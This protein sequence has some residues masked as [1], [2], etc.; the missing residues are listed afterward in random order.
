MSMSLTVAPYATTTLHVRTTGTTTPR[1]AEKPVTPRTAG[2]RTRRTLRPMQ[3]N[4]GIGDVVTVARSPIAHAHLHRAT[5]TLPYNAPGDPVVKP[6]REAAQWQVGHAQGAARAVLPVTAARTRKTHRK[7]AHEVASSPIPATPRHQQQHN[8]RAACA[9][10]GAEAG[11]VAALLHTMTPARFLSALDTPAP[12]MSDAYRQTLHAARLLARSGA[13]CDALM[14]CLPAKHWTTLQREALRI[15]LHASEAAQQPDAR[16]ATRRAAEQEVAAA[17]HALDYLQA[18]PAASAADLAHALREAKLLVPYFNRKHGFDSPRDV[19]LAQEMLL[20]Y[21][22][23]LR[24]AHKLRTSWHARW[25]PRRLIGRKKS[26]LSAM[27]KRMTGLRRDLAHRERERLDHALRQA[28]AALFADPRRETILRALFD[29]AAPEHKL[30]VVRQIVILRHLHAH[31][32]ADRRH[33]VA[34]QRPFFAPLDLTPQQMAQHTLQEIQR[35][36]PDLAGRDAALLQKLQ[37]EARVML[38][39]ASQLKQQHWR[40]PTV[41]HLLAWHAQW[42]AALDRAQLHETHD[43][44]LRQALTKLSKHLHDAAD[45]TADDPQMR[46]MTPDGVQR[47][48]DEM[49]GRMHNHSA[50]F[51]SG[52]NVGV[53]ARVV[54]S[55]LPGIGLRPKLKQI[56]GRDAVISVGQSLSG[57]YLAIGRQSRREGEIGVDAVFGS[58]AIFGTDA[59][60]LQ[61]NLS[62]GVDA[63]YKRLRGTGLMIRADKLLDADG[64]VITWNEA[65]HPA[66]GGM[67]SNRW[68]MQK[69]NAFLCRRC[70]L[71]DGAMTIPRDAAALWEDFAAAFFDS[72]NLQLSI[73]RDSKTAQT[74]GA[75]AQAAAKVGNSHLGMHASAG[76]RI[77]LGRERQ[78]TQERS[79]RNAAMNGGH[80][81][82]HAIVADAKL[83][84]ALPNVSTTGSAGG[85]TKVSAPPVHAVDAQARFA[86]QRHNVQYRLQQVDGKLAASCFRYE[87]VSTLADLKAILQRDADVWHGMTNGDAH[88]AHFYAEYA[89]SYGH[90]PNTVFYVI[91]DLR[92]SAAEQIDAIHFELTLLETRLAQAAYDAQAHWNAHIAALQ[93]RR[94]QIL[95]NRDNWLPYAIDVRLTATLGQRTGPGLGLVLQHTE[96]VD[97]THMLM[98]LTAK[99]E[100]RHA[101]RSRF[102]VA[103]KQFEGTLQ[104]G[105]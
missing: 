75:G 70:V 69:V 41:Q 14:A 86:E 105:G 13:G 66:P 23:D 33:G 72:P 102:E 34:Q 11:E 84:L 83:G 87:I 56:A 25:H 29:S 15:W 37:Q 57:S 17:R 47:E 28:A 54:L 82:R 52:S 30:E 77:E 96:G 31:A 100:Q 76:V 20:A 8:L 16:P 60:P 6:P 50:T 62:V 97:E 85:L 35:L 24:R 55:F 58:D 71:E 89:R 9:L 80:Q 94:Q 4:I 90:L 68:T 59:V 46:D 73:Y 99:P 93:A 45:T 101:A 49:Y 103:R 2:A 74:I 7:P 40:P 5:A 67:D 81:T 65:G 36:A 98:R 12:D 78:R 44:A 21:G 27:Y 18:H 32:E 3:Y 19:K 88:L 53:A 63:G 79:T 61:G 64:R 92:R 38:T 22:I 104:Q 1:P 48:F 26:A 39:P 51:H 91:C 42:L 10:A 43:E 95:E